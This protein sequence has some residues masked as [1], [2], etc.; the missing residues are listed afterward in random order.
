MSALRQ[1]WPSIALVAAAVLLILPLWLAGTPAMPDYPARLA[2]FYLIGGGAGTAPLSN[3]YGV[4]W[5]LIPNL[6]SEIIVP[7]LARLLPLEVAVKLFLSIAV[8]MW[9]A[10]PALIHRALYGRIGL[11][12]LAA[13]FFAY[14][15][16]F[17]WGFI[18]YYFATGLCLI[19]FA[20]WIA[21]AA[22]PRWPRLLVFAV[23]AVV[24]Y[25]CHIFG[26][27]LLLLLVAT[28]EAA[29]NPVRWRALLLDIAV[30]AVPVAILYLIKPS[31]PA[32]GVV[33]MGL[34]DSFPH[35]ILSIVQLHFAAPAYLVIL[36]L[37][38]LF[39]IGFWQKKVTLHPRM[40]FVLGAITVLAIFIP[41]TAMG[42]WGLHLR[43][44]AVAATLLFAACEIT[45]P[46]RF[47]I[48]AGAVI[49]VTIAGMS[50]ALTSQW[51]SY[52][53]Q[54]EEFRASLRDTPRGS[55]LMTAVDTHNA[56]K[57]PNRLYWHMAEFS[58]IDRSDFTSLMF[59]TRGQHIVMVKP[60]VAGFAAHDLLGGIPPDMDDLDALASGTQKNID[61]LDYLSHFPCHYDEVLLIHANGKPR[62]V[63]HM[64]KLRHEGSFFALYDV[65]PSRGCSTISATRP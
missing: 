30:I 58:I 56:E 52:D 12:P 43:L 40:L 26:A 53:S 36:A 45:A 39:A 42:G 13:A 57:V 29:R 10:G 16:N 11:A 3:F 44:P 62:E 8:A 60:A 50:A 34:V 14:N 28:Y 49:V 33:R 54:I 7:L 19:A 31:D 51:R 27:A 32:H 2:G 1:G 18:N 17:M 9:V 25:F 5:A 55:H 63:P 38:A 64:L 47:V 35:R 48:A 59:A 41:Q 22:W 37:A 23:I 24:L 21:S 46:R 20:G 61:Y 4:G 65:R 15:V 6:A